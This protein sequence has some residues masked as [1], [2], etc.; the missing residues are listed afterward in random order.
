LVH[1]RGAALVW[2]PTSNFFTLGKTLDAR[3][4][5]SY[6]RIAL[7]SDSALTAQGDLLDELRAAHEHFQV[8]SELLYAMVTTGAADVLRLGE[9]EG[10]LRKWATAD[11]TVLKWRGDSPA[12]SLVQASFKEIHAVIV[13]G[14]LALASPQLAKRWPKSALNGLACLLVEGTERWVRAPVEGLIK[15]SKAYLGESIRLAGKQVSA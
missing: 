4:V 13:G 2:C 1:K 11:L 10:S 12:D 15:V 14:R 5:G 8:S 3:A 7:G 6:Q 9:G